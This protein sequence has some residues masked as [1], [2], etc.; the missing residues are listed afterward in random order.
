[1]LHGPWSMVLSSLNLQED[2]QKCGGNAT[3]KLGPHQPI[4][5]QAFGCTKHFMPLTVQRL[6]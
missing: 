3:L 2:P 4:P 5:G 1:M 6:R